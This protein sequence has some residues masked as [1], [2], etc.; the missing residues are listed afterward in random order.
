MPEFH[1]RVSNY[2]MWA[3]PQSPYVRE[4]LDL[5]VKV[6]TRIWASRVFTR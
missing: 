1:I 5:I 4:V 6:R 3:A 2:F